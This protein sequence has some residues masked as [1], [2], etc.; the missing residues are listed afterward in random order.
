MGRNRLKCSENTFGWG[1][2]RSFPSFYFAGF[3]NFLQWIDAAFIIRKKTRKQC[4]RTRSPM[5]PASAVTD[6]MWH[7]H[8]Y[9]RRWRCRQRPLC[10]GWCSL[11]ATGFLCTAQPSSH[12]RVCCRERV[13]MSHSDAYMFLVAQ[14]ALPLGRK[15]WMLDLD[16]EEGNSRGVACLSGPLQRLRGSWCSPI[17]GLLEASQETDIWL[18]TLPMGFV[19]K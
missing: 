1:I 14:V 13:G 9:P 12:Y 2:I 17:T 8:A 11:A 6:C 5:W 10:F 4:P 15:A 3:P 19:K 18:F 16:G 7:G